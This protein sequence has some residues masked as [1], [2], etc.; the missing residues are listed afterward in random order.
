MHVRALLVLCLFASVTSAQDT[1]SQVA[2]STPTATTNFSLVG[3]IVTDL[4]RLQV[5][6]T[7]T[8][9]DIEQLR[10]EKWK[11]DG[12]T[13]QQ[14]QS[15]AQSI[16]RNLTSALPGMIAAARA[17]PQDL[18]AEFKLY[19]NLNAVY[20]VLASVT[21]SAGA[22]GTR[23]EYDAL[24]RQLATIGTVRHNLGESLEQLAASIQ[25]ELNQL[26]AQ[27][28]TLQR[29]AAAASTPPKKVVVDDAEPAKKSSTSRKKTTAA[30]PASAD[31]ASS[32]TETKN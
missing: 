19:R 29:Q 2:N 15:D 32:G 3:K 27:V 6:A 14:A 5:A 23:S 4:D 30:K 24:A 8:S 22:F 17:A 18:G 26:R 10:I 9:T 16:R 28:Q 31:A 1:A 13:K 21:E 11:T 25:T 12:A 20:D 7:Q